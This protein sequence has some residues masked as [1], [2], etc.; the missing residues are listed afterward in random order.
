[1]N[2]PVRANSDTL[3][4]EIGQRWYNEAKT[5][6]LNLTGAHLARAAADPAGSPIGSSATTA[7]SGSGSRLGGSKTG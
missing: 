4:C 1:V 3:D 7:W 6:W 2:Q 5:Q